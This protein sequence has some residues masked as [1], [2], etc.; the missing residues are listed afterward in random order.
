M[1]ASSRWLVTA[2]FLLA[3]L[4]LASSQPAFARLDSPPAVELAPLLAPDAP[5]P[6][7]HFLCY[8]VA[9]GVPVSKTVKLQD[10][11]DRK[12]RK[13]LVWDPARLCNPVE[14]T[15]NTKVTNILYPNDHLVLYNIGKHSITPTLKVQVRNQFGAQQLD[16][17]KPAEVLMV[18]SRKL[19]HGKPQNTDH[20]KC[21][22]V[23]GQPV[24]ATV[25]LKDQFQQIPQTVVLQPFGLCNPTR[26]FHKQRWTEVLHPDAHLVC[27]FVQPI[28]FTKTVTTVNQFRRENLTTTAADLLCAPSRKKVLS[29]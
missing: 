1:S 15:H 7:N 27:Y 8:R 26:K 22:Y 5:L 14:K 24:N 18:P 6:L 23:Q 10:Q 19:P 17:F 25:D 4:V 13:A 29:N 2:A 16:V 21:Y 20:F 9:T 28:N 3:V 12:P 11:F